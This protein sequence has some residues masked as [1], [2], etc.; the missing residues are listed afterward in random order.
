MVLLSFLIHIF[1]L[2]FIAIDSMSDYAQIKGQLFSKFHISHLEYNWAFPHQKNTMP[3]G[4]VT[5]LYL[6]EV[7]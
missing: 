5:H 6:I 2:F 3:M 4:F 7:M 1:S